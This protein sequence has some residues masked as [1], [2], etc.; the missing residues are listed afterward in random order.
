MPP[1]LAGLTT[2]AKALR[3]AKWGGVA[4]LLQC[5]R[6]TLGNIVILNA[7][8]KPLDLAIAWFMG[9]SIIP[10]LYLITGIRLWRGNGAIFGNFAG[11]VFLLDLGFN[12]S[13][14]T[15]IPGAIAIVVRVGLCV[16]LLNGVRAAHAL[17]TVDYSKEDA[18][19][20][21]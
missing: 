18:R 9:A 13:I 21:T 10:A 16:L 17:Q 19:A 5:T 7:T 15:S 6:M 12:S 3:A 14:P 1:W 2:E 8:H 4:C 20:F 11:I